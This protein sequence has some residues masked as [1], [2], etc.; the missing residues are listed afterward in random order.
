MFDNSRKTVKVP[1]F[2]LASLPAD[3]QKVAYEEWVTKTKDGLASSHEAEQF[4]E[5]LDGLYE[6]FGFVICD[7]HCEF[8]YVNE[9][10]GYENEKFAGPNVDF[11]SVIKDNEGWGIFLGKIDRSFLRTDSK[12]EIAN[13]LNSLIESGSYVDNTNKYSKL[14]SVFINEKYQEKLKLLDKDALGTNQHFYIAIRA[15]QEGFKY[16]FSVF[17]TDLKALSLKEVFVKEVGN[18]P[19]FLA[20]GSLFDIDADLYYQD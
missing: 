5:V 13:D 9:D 14:W 7:R 17:A 4:K 15:M 18:H 10:L 8:Y 6:G 20:D 19:L 1:L 3:A 16:T 11:D 12:E 2:T